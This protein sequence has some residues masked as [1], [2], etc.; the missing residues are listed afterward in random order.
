[1]KG[2]R[3]TLGLIPIL[4]KM[5]PHEI[6]VTLLDMLEKREFCIAGV[7]LDAGFDSG[8]TLLLLQERWLNY[9]VPLKRNNKGSNRRNV[10]FERN[11]S[12]PFGQ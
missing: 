11:R 9:T 5:K 8:E 1:M 12:R 4:P 6:V 3:Y 10:L 2:Q 7:A